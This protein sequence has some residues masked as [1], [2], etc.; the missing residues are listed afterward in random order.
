MSS[1]LITNKMAPKTLIHAEAVAD[2]KDKIQFYF[3]Y[4]NEGSETNA[5]A[6]ELLSSFFM[7]L[8]THDKIYLR[9]SDFSVV[10]AEL[11]SGD[12]LKLLDRKIISTVFGT[13][14]LVIRREPG[15]L[16]L[17]YMKFEWSELD[18]FE[19]RI[20]KSLLGGVKSK[21]IQF[22]ENSS[23]RADALSPTV[24]HELGKDLERESFRSGLD[25]FTSKT[26]KIN[27]DDGYKVLRL[28]E[29]AQSLILQNHLDA[30][31]LYQDA[32]VRNYAEAKFGAFSNLATKDPIVGFEKVLNL[33]GIP[34]IYPLYKK[35]VVSLDDILRCREKFNGGVFRK[36]YANVDFDN[37]E[38][39]AQ[40]LSPAKQSAGSKLVR[41]LYPNIIGVFSPILGL[42]ASAADSYLL[43]KLVSGWKPSLF[44][45]D[46]LK[47]SIDEKIKEFGRKTKQ[48][49][50][51][52]R[53]GSIGRNEACP[54]QSGKKF[55]KCH[56]A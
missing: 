51:I 24:M 15:L 6:K 21:V 19:K 27:P 42:A 20:A 13:D 35:G 7:S 1:I 18:G 28:A 33:K 36:W 34:D 32:Q 49:E 37:E 48:K 52:D 56:G 9:P 31:S 50:M 41:L 43:D 8:I 22:V 14:E 17:S 2:K 12:T 30:D 39:V 53:F 3:G 40:L 44:L 45:D 46:V 16:S 11:G 54:C 38:L 47:S 5:A 10:L 4:L 29:C 55:K 26:S 25:I 23:V